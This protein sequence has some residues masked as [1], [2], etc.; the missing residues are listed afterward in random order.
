MEKKETPKVNPS[1]SAPSPSQAT[2]PT[3]RKKRS[4]KTPEQSQPPVTQ[5]TQPKEETVPVPKKSII[6]KMSQS[7][8]EKTSTPSTSAQT[9]AQATNTK[10]TAESSDD[11][12]SNMAKLLEYY[13]PVVDMID[14]R[15]PMYYAALMQHLYIDFIIDDDN[16]DSGTIDKNTYEV[17]KIIEKACEKLKFNVYN[18]T[19]PEIMKLFHAIVKKLGGTTAFRVHDLKAL[20][21]LMFRM[22]SDAEVIEFL[23]YLYKHKIK[24][25][26]VLAINSDDEVLLRN[27]KSIRMEPSEKWEEFIEYMSEKD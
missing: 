23:Y 25:Q 14:H 24:P 6:D 8:P 5:Q 2:Q 17:G 18:A 19:I 12:V 1:T 7:A 22:Y 9:V 27:G 21:M 4:T 10:E 15:N 20:E 16:D 13:Q 26:D 11:R 3:P